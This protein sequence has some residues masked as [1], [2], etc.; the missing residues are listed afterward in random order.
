MLW[1]MKYS[2]IL[3][4]FLVLL[5][6]VASLAAVAATG[7]TESATPVV[8]TDQLTRQLPFNPDIR[9]GR[10]RNGLEYFVLHHPH[11]QDSVTL[12]LIVDAGSILETDSQAG[13]AHFVEHMA[14]NGTAE[15]DE[16]ELVAYLEQLG[17]QFGPDV[18]AYTSFDE[19]VYKLDIPAE[20]EETLHTGF[21][22]M[23]Q[24][25]R[26]I[27]FEQDAL[28]RERGVIVEEW[29]G[30]QNASQRILRR[31]IPVLLADSRYAE[32]L[33]IGDMDIVRNAP[34]EEFLDFYQR[35]YRPDNMAFVAVGDLPADQLE[36]LVHQYFDPIPA[37]ETPLGRPYYHAPFSGEIRAS[38]ATDSE[39]QRSTIALYRL[40][41]PAPFRTE[42]DYRRVLA[43]SLFASALNERFRDIARDPRSSFTQAGVGWNRFLRDTEIAVAS[44]VIR[45]DR[46]TDA[47]RTVMEE[48]H[49][50]EQHGFLPQEIRRGKDRLLQ[51]I[52]ESL[53]NFETRRSAVLADELVRHWTEGEAVPGIQEEHRLYHRLLPEITVDEVNRVVREFLAEDGKTVLAGIR[54]EDDGAMPGGDAVPEPQDLIDTVHDVRE[55]SLEP[56][57]EEDLPPQLTEQFPPAGTVD[58]TKQHDEVGVTEARLSNG[59][60][61]FL[62]PTDFREDEILFS[63]YSPGGLSLVEDD[64][65]GAAKLA[66]AVV[67]ASGIGEVNA[68]TLERILSGRSVSVSADISRAAETMSGNSRREDL[69]LLFQMI[70]LH[71]TEPRFE[72]DQLENLRRRTIQSLQGRMASPQGRFSRRLEELFSG[73]D[74]RLRS[75]DT[76]EV[77]QTEREDTEEVFRRRFGR[78]ED[79]I[80][81]FVGSFEVEEM[82]PLLERY[83]ASIPPGEPAGTEESSGRSVDDFV[84]AVGDSPVSRPEG[85][86]D[87]VLRAGTDPVGQTVILI[88]GPFEWS[89]EEN[90]RFNSLGELLDIRLRETI[91]E[92]AGGSYSVGAGG[93]R[94]RYPEGWSYMQLYYGMDPDRREE[95][96]ETAYD[97]IGEV[98]ERPV[99]G[100]YLQRIQ[101][102][103]RETYRRSVRENSYWLGTIEF[104]ARHG[105]DL[106]EITGYP[107]L[108]ESLTAEDIQETARRYLDPERRIQLMLLP[109]ED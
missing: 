8:Q 53:V 80:L 109:Q 79:F 10:L 31:H 45:D 107:E 40:Q 2:G 59:M 11:P 37:P 3:R 104:Y 103:Q 38:V 92:D 30:G 72:E 26:A 66:P 65:V 89:R 81:T 13:L 19:T 95:L 54:V 70:H 23:E 12:R 6:S 20:E 52:D 69:E 58:D 50:V 47:L 36:D 39:L 87:E 98:R 24:W 33:P 90:H 77:E 91:R 94:W 22:V 55:V 7:V 93:W 17:I 42:N 85:A 57:V 75:P 28:D 41:E 102:T 48:L 21:R 16:N 35:W 1:P 86:I 68:A 99:D 25:A 96:L 43:H 18:N 15:F 4:F 32:R 46:V 101:A 14:F 60:R 76:T 71:F 97:V 5:L 78:P 74:P 34:R 106:K 73:G 51:S 61:V 88:H 82:V 67:R 62:K 27:S 105:R 44:A 9:S 56:R 84:E 100:D 108:I 49:R 64:L 83:L 29:R 63:A